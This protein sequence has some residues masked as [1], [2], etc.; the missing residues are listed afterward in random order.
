MK[1][2]NEVANKILVLDDEPAIRELC[3]RVLTREGFEVDTA[4]SGIEGQQLAG[5]KKYD[6]CLI[7]IKMPGMNG[8]EFYEWIKAVYPQSVNRII[9]TTGSLIDK[10][11][12]AFMAKTGGLLL[13]KPFNTE[14][15][16][17]MIKEFFQ[18]GKGKNEYKSSQNSGSRR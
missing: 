12:V 2:S 15:L 18:E 7:D 5:K 8:I 9:F 6:L 13:S 1:G 17:T 14:E 16:V 4:T 3:R 10:N 11:T